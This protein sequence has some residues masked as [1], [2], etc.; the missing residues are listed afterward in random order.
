MDR[1]LPRMTGKQLRRTKRLIRR[2]CANYE[3]GNCLALDDGEPC[4]C[5]QT[6]SYS[7]LCRYF[8]DAVLPADPALH[9]EVME[10]DASRRCKRCG[11]PF[12]PTG[13][14][15]LDGKE[16]SGIQERKRKAAW[17]RKHRAER[18]RLG[19]QKP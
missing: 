9:A 13:S 3:D 1:P 18:G 7:L 12:L 5:P 2:L 16:C 15:S 10:K 8:H 4:V 11:G 14:R 19:P 6:I 17:A